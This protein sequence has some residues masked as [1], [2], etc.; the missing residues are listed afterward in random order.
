MSTVWVASIAYRICSRWIRASRWPATAP[1][2]ARI[3]LRDV[4]RARRSESVR[5]SSWVTTSD[6]SCGPITAWKYD[7]SRRVARRTISAMKSSSGMPLME[8]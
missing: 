3:A 1:L 2:R 5:I 6:P 8:L 4:K 7:C